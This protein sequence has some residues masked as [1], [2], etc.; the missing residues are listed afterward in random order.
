[1]YSTATGQLSQ[2]IGANST[3]LGQSAQAIASNSVALGT[4]SI[5][6]RANSVSVG[7]VGAERQITNVAEGTAGTDGVNVNQLYRTGALAAALS[8]LQPLPY[9]PAQKA[10]ISIAGGSFHNKQAVALGLNYYAKDSVL[11]N[12][13]VSYAE[14]ETMIRGGITWKLGSKK[15]YVPD[16]SI[17]SSLQEQ[18]HGLQIQNQQLKADNQQKIDLLQQQFDQLIKKLN[19]DKNKENE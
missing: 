17:S 5:A 2:A 3:A 14:N 1:M 9:D 6:D 15:N 13:G 11:M 12:L 10:Q 7:S 19:S 4:N 18:I 16:S 8:G